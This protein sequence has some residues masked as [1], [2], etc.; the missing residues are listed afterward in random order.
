MH[1]LTFWNAYPCHLSGLL[2]PSN[3]P[4]Q[5]GLE[6]LAYTFGGQSTESTYALHSARNAVVTRWV[7]NFARHVPRGPECPRGPASPGSPLS[8][9]S[10]EILT[11][12]EPFFTR[13][14]WQR[15][16]IR[17]DTRIC[18]TFETIFELWNVAPNSSHTRNWIFLLLLY[19][20]S[21]WALSSALATD[22]LLA[23]N[24]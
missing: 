12:S 9:L 1:F 20:Q 21:H 10:P 14:Q 19:Y 13:F 6:G 5:A 18:S 2:A 22:C 7:W 15:S 24:F 3:Q 17:A 8:P 4:L 23:V 16:N 11:K